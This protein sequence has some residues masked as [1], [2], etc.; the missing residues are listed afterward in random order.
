[1]LAL[2]EELQKECDTQAKKIVDNFVNHREFDNKSQQV[3]QSL[4]AASSYKATNIH[5]K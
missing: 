1:M 2:M 3:M 5:D 4:R